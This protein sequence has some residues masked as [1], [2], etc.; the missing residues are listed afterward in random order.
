MWSAAKR[1]AD[2]FCHNNRTIHLNPMNQRRAACKAY[3][4]KTRWGGIPEHMHTKSRVEAD[5]H[6]HTN[7][8]RCNSLQICF[9]YFLHV[10]HAQPCVVTYSHFLFW[11]RARH[12]WLA[13]TMFSSRGFFSSAHMYQ[14]WHWR[15]VVINQS[16]GHF[17]AAHHAITVAFHFSTCPVPTVISTNSLLNDMYTHTHTH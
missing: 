11:Y 17:A 8:Q 15:M 14:E 13:S 6:A 1:L 3:L 5:T 9:L 4:K 12:R 16:N 2:L 10:A 7:S